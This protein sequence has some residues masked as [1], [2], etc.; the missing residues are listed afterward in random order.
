MVRRIVPVL[1]LT[2]ALITACNALPAPLTLDLKSRMGS[3]SRGSVQE[4]VTAGGSPT[5]DVT[6]PSSGGQCI[7]FSDR[8]IAAR[9]VDATIHYEVEV[10]YSGPPLTGQVQAR[11]YAASTSAGLWQPAAQ[12]GPAVAVDLDSTATTL[13]GSATLDA[14]QVKAVNDRYV[15]WGVHLTGSNVN[16]SQSGT[17]TIRYTVDRLTADA[18]VSVMAASAR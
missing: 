17:A 10:S 14:D 9:L 3:S 7:D 1:L 6:W 12:V 5:L 15:C 4:P 2:T 16:A 8:K 13:A 11:L 18:G